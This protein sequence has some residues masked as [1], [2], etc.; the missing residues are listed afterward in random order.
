MVAIGAKQHRLEIQQ[1]VTTPDQY[2]DPVVAWT[3]I[4]T[5]WASIEP[6][7][8]R[9]RL[10]G[11]QIVGEMDTRIKV[12]WGAITKQITAAHRGVHQGVVFN[13]VS[14]AHIKLEQREIEIMAKSGVNDG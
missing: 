4:G 10:L 6:M 5:V 14:I 11:D 12:R 3:T 8:G 13:F 9:E 7:K 2:G 1:P